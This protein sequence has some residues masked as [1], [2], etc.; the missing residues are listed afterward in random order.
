MTAKGPKIVNILLDG[1]LPDDVL[2]TEKNQNH[3]VQ[4]VQKNYQQK[5]K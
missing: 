5:G 1:I 3:K 4:Q 2:T